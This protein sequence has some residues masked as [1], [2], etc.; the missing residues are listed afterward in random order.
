MKKLLVLLTAML[1]LLTVSA[2]A[3]TATVENVL[4]TSENA[5]YSMMIPEDFLPVDDSY[6]EMVKSRIEKGLLPGVDEEMLAGMQTSLASVDLSQMDMILSRTLV[7]NINIQVQ[8]MGVPGSLLSV[9]KDQL[10]EVNIKSYAVAGVTSD[11]ITTHD[12]EE[13]GNY[14]WYHLSCSM[15][16]REIEQYIAADETGLAYI[17]T[18]TGIDEADMELILTT[19][20]FE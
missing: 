7:G 13:I 20:Q 19:F 8:Y 1:L 6:I 10:D 2:S 12:V 18:F 9:Y 4:Y 14:N 15:L 16:G 3:E 17:L 11:N 5:N